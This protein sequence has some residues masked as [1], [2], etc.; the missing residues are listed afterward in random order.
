MPITMKRR[1][2]VTGGAPGFGREIARRPHEGGPRVAIVDADGGARLGAH[3][4]V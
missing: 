2:V 4:A 1:G 3:P